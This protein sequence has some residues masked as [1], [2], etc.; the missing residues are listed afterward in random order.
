MKGNLFL[1]LKAQL[2]FFEIPNGRALKEFDRHLTLLFF[3]QQDPVFTIERLDKLPCFPLKFSP[4]ALCTKTL[5]LSSVAALDV[6]FL[7]KN[8]VFASYLRE[9]ENHFCYHQKRPWLPHITVARHPTDQGSWDLLSFP[10]PCFFEGL[11]LYR[12]LGNSAFEIL[13]RRDFHPFFQPLDHT[14]D[15]GYS[16]Y[17]ESFNELY[18]HAL[19]LLSMEYPSLRT[20]LRSKDCFSIEDVIIC[21]NNVI[22][23]VDTEQGIGIKAVS[24]HSK[25]TEEKDC[26]RWDM[27]IDI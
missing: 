24:F 22:S 2:P 21:L 17:G 12:S 18:L 7:N 16:I 11:A 13:W 4:L 20:H 3:G 19:L 25:I 9:L 5:F 15:Y 10:F 8:E 1:G 23:Y 27:I 14:A 26:L 6:L